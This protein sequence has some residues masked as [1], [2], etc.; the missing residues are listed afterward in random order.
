M[1]SPSPDG[2]TRRR[3]I[4]TIGAAALGGLSG[5]GGRLPGTDPESLDA[6]STV[7]TDGRSRLLWE[8]P[9]RDGDVDGIGYASVE[10]SSVSERD[11]LPSRAHLSFNSTVGG[12]ASDEP[13][14]GFV[15]EWF[16]F[17]VRPPSTAGGAYEVGVRP[18]GR[19]EEFSV[20]YDGAAGVRRTTVELGAVGTQ[21]TIEVPA[22]FDPSPD[23]GGLPDRLHCT[24]AVRASRPGTFGRTVR[25]DAR[26]TLPLSGE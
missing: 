19:W 5:C 2:T 23:M 4:A 20:Y 12:I 7:E 14:E 11:G 3:A 6:E 10:V 25:V 13:Y 21:G 9:P 24:F 17:R 8:Y 26:G 16:R 18:P 1:P 22:T 15:P